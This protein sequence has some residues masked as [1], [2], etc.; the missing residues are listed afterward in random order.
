MPRCMYCPFLTTDYE[1]KN[2]IPRIKCEFASI[3]FPNKR[4]L[5]LYVQ[6]YCA[7]ERGWQKCTVAQSTTEYYERSDLDG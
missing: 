5:D 3:K 4:E 7:S 1:S 6:K 2:G